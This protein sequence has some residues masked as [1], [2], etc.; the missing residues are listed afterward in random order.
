[1]DPEQPSSTLSRRGLLGA[2]GGALA[3]AALPA[4]ARAAATPVGPGL[5]A[6]DQ[7]FALALSTLN[8][9]ITGATGSVAL[10]R[11]DNM[12]VLGGQ[13]ASFGLMR[14]EANGGLREPHWHPDS[15]E[16]QYYL[17]GHARV[18]IVLITGDCA[19]LDVGPGDMVFLPQ[20]CGHSILNTGDEGIQALLVFQVDTP[21]S[22]GLGNFFSGMDTG[23]T[24]QTLGVPTSTLASAP[25]PP[26]GNP[27]P[28]R[29]A[30]GQGAGPSLPRT[31]QQLSFPLLGTPPQTQVPGGTV[32][33]CNANDLPAMQGANAAM[34]L[35]RLQPGA[36]REPHWHPEAWEINLCVGGSG[37]IGIVLPD[38]TQATYAV[39]PGDVVFVPQGYG[40][41]I[42]NTGGG[43]MTFVSSFNADVP[44]TIG[45][46][47][48]YDGIATATTAQTLRVKP[49]V[50][51]PIPRPAAPPPIV[52]PLSS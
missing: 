26:R 39:G 19:Q 25:K 37:Q 7:D 14:I 35:V 29:Q 51:A 42:L 8:P 50:L 33:H 38:S 5:P 30:G 1:M 9:Q 4:A 45:L 11:L 41:Y 27:F 3:V 15:W 32:T 21:R 46:G 43:D 10:G 49:A 16:L 22:I 12:P 17:G 48:L 31:G 47:D 2:A 13:G 23:V 44:T 18:E 20:G 52:P 28:A 34:V 24:T 6:T 40:H 36:L